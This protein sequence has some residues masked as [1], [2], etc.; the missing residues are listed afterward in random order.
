M[1]TLE[2]SLLMYRQALLQVLAEAGVPS[3]P[4]VDDEWILNQISIKLSG[5][6]IRWIVC[7]DCYRRFPG[8]GS[9]FIHYSQYRGCCKK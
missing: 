6:S 9:F 2:E 7:Q 3:N 8:E 1:Q 5:K 4:S